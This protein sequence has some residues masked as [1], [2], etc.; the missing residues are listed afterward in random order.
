MFAV[1]TPLLCLRVVLWHRHGEDVSPLIVKNVA[2]IVV[3][4]MDLYQG[5][6][7]T[8]DSAEPNDD[9]ALVSL[10]DRRSDQMNIVRYNNL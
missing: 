1:N 2:M 9:R 5:E 6:D 3:S 4:A 7:Q 8:A 10:G